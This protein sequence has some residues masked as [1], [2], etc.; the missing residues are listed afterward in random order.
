MWLASLLFM[1]LS[2]NY[3][4]I[5]MGLAASDAKIT[6]DAVKSKILQDVRGCPYTTLTV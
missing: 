1:G 6:A 3:E 5:I 4:P 2:E